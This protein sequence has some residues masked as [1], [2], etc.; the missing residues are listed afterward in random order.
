MFGLVADFVFR[1]GVVWILV[2]TVDGDVL[3]VWVG[4]EGSLRTVAVV[5]VE[6]EDGDPGLGARAGVEEVVRGDCHDGVVDVAVPTRAVGVAVMARWATK[7][8]NCLGR[9]V[10]AGG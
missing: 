7:C 10:S 5:K 8:E 6:V 4:P 1:A 2:P 3:D 9:G